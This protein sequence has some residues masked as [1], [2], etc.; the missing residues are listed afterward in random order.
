MIWKFL[1]GAFFF[2]SC[3]AEKVIII[4][5]GAA[6]IATASR[7]LQNN[8][9][10]FRILEAEK[11]IGGRIHSVHFGDAFVELGAQYVH[12]TQGNIVYQISKDYFD[13]KD[14]TN[15]THVYYR[16]RV[17]YGDDFIKEMFPIQRDIW[18]RSVFNDTFGNV[19]LKWYNSTVL[20]TYKNDQ[21]MLNYAKDAIKTAECI[22]LE[23]TGSSSW[24][25]NIASATYDVL[26]GSQLL[27]W[28]G[29]GY[30][31]VLDIILGNYPKK[32]GYNINKWISFNETVTKINLDHDK[33]KIR[34]EDGAEITSDYVVF[35]P[36]L[37]VLK[38]EERSIFE[39]NLNTEKMKA[40]ESL[41]YNG[42]MKIFF[43]FPNRW[44]GNEERIYFVW[45]EEDKRSFIKDVPFGPSKEGDHWLTWFFNIA[46][47]PNNPKVLIGWIAGRMVKEVEALTNEELK[48]ATMYAMRKALGK[49]FNVTEPIKIIQ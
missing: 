2:A 18:S 44:W 35:T 21:N 19:F 17:N 16:T 9:T 1:L 3:S 27:S 29:I 45:S 7:L 37:G 15:I 14:E 30:K 40:I 13:F 48:Y 32:T 31:I 11:R 23:E 4:G 20:N 28:N 25:D 36:S 24:F 38:H 5:A 39:P 10:D 49:T 43:E 8:I 12:G 46:I 6:G 41:G 33:V 22:N 34:T 26:P 42:V 47:A